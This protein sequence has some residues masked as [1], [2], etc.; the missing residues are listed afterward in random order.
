MKP[1]H[2]AVV[3]R[4][5][6]DTH[7]TICTCKTTTKAKAIRH[8]DRSIWEDTEANRKKRQELRDGVERGYGATTFINHV[9][10]STAPITIE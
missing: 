9:L 8:F 3:G 5:P 4:I 2:W 1:K 7:D 6:E 10:S